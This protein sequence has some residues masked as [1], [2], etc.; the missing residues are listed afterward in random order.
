MA[1]SGRIWLLTDRSQK[2]ALTSTLGG[3]RVQWTTPAWRK[4]RLAAVLRRVSGHAKVKV[5]KRR[6]STD[7]LP[8]ATRVP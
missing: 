6:W 4:S 3:I 2:I 7:W 1:I 8:Q 5:N